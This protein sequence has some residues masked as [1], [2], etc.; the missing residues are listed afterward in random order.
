MTG[1]TEGYSTSYF[2]VWAFGLP[3]C[4]IPVETE[5]WI[6]GSPDDRKGNWTRKLVFSFLSMTVCRPGRGPG[7]DWVQ[8]RL[9]T[10]SQQIP[11]DRRIWSEMPI[12]I[13]FLQA[14]CLSQPPSL[15]SIPMA[16]YFHRWI[17]GS[18]YKQSPQLFIFIFIERGWQR[19][20]TV[21]ICL[22]PLVNCRCCAPNFQS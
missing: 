9:I 15:I 19:V 8:R 7:A 11:R 21:H 1:W 17:H 22:H 4:T 5:A 2:L 10:A 18:S 12:V 16:E 13:G 6:C 20:L 14:G 3:S